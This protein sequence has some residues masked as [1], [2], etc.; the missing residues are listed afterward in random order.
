MVQNL[1]RTLVWLRPWRHRMCHPALEDLLA[2]MR[3]RI[4]KPREER[5]NQG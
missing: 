1:L 5:G 2:G 3:H 4:D